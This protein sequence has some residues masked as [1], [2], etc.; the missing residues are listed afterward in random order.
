MNNIQKVF[1]RKSL[2][3]HRDRASA[4]IYEYDFLFKVLAERLSDKLLDVK[5]SFSM[6]LE[7]GCH[8]QILGA[9]LQSTGKVKN[10]ISCD[11]SEKMMSGINSEKAVVDEEFIPFSK[12][13]FDL[14]LSSGSFHWVNDAPGSLIQ[15]RNII[16]PDGLIL[17]NFFGGRTLCE[18]RYCLVSAEEQIR[19]GVTQRVSPFA[20]VKDAG[21]LMQRAGF[22]SIVTDSEEVVIR[23]QEPINL[24][25][26]LRGMGETNAISERSKHFTSSAVIKRA[27]EIYV[28]QF[29]D[30]E[31][32]SKATFEIIT[33]TGWVESNAT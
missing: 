28:D 17:I 25:Y 23:Y 4:K 29:G 19:G 27:C 20:D 30:Y 21:Q 10:I 1:D 9:A 14:V 31:G 12:Q 26:D 32:L 18:L 13:S 7:L 15:I 3:L 11:I 33:M 22:S 24:M 5:R 6:A 8:Q 2:R 16:R